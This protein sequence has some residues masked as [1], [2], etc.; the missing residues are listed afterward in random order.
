MRE[1]LPLASAAFALGMAAA[2]EAKADQPVQAE[3]GNITCAVEAQKP[4]VC[5][6]PNGEV[7][8]RI[9]GKLS[10]LQRQALS[11]LNLNRQQILDRLIPPQA[12]VN[13]SSVDRPEVSDKTRQSGE[14]SHEWRRPFKALISGEKLYLT[15]EEE[16]W[17]R[18]MREE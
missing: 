5:T 11:R 1:L 8:F 14:G 3:T 10:A 13:R 9:D 18:R 16:D 6:N 7:L 2:P 12:K 17:L 15:P 4:V